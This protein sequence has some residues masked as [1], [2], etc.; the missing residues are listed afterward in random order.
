MRPEP[1]A[2]L[3]IGRFGRIE[4][5]DEYACLLFG[6]S[7]PELLHLHGTDLILPEDRPRVAVSIDLMRE[8]TVTKRSGRVLR[9][10][11]VVV[12]VDVSAKRLRDSRLALIV[13]PLAAGEPR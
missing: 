7:R 2:T 4:D 3:V 5:V 10:D 8:G 13:R 12:D 9:K 1:A 6:Y 11:R